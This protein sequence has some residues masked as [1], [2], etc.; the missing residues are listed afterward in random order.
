MGI[1][2]VLT[3][4]RTTFGECLEA[5]L[6]AELVDND[7]WRMLVKLSEEAGLSNAAEKFRAALREEE[8]HLSTVRLWLEELNVS[9]LSLRKKVA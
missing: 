2:K 1:Q 5:I 7:A 6:I 4:S 3:D 9:Q 8:D